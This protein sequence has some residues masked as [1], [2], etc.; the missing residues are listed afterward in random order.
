M[1]LVKIHHKKKR[2]TSSSGIYCEDPFD[3]VVFEIFIDILIVLFR[4]QFYRVLPNKFYN[5]GVNKQLYQK[6]SSMT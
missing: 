3:K 6:I 5:F 4:A 1:S 2:K